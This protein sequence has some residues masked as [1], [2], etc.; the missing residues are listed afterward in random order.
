[1][2]SQTFKK[3]GT[4]RVYITSNTLRASIKLNT[5][6]VKIVLVKIELS[7]VQ[8]ELGNDSRHAVGVYSEVF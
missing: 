3:L 1:M 7:R 5:S 4:L 2:T 6:E 8:A